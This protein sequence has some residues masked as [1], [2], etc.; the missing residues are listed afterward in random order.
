MSHLLWVQYSQGYSGCS[1]SILH[2]PFRWL[3]EKVFSDPL[4]QVV[5]KKVFRSTG[6][7]VSEEGI[8]RSTCSRL[9][10]RCPLIHRSRFLR[11]RLFFDPLVP[12]C[13]EGILRSTGSLYLPIFQVL[14]V[15]QAAQKVFFHPPFRWLKEKVFSD[16]LVQV[17]QKK[18]F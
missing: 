9:L 10:R 17:V 6:P 8:L 14:R 4:V 13:S 11:R 12:G 7:G 15:T 18:V 5:Q 16:P 1:E 2:P 3:K